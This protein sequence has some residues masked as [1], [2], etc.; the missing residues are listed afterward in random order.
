MEL[1]TLF[2]ALEKTPTQQSSSKINLAGT[3]IESLI[4]A[5]PVTALVPWISAWEELRRPR[6]DLGHGIGIAYPNGKIAQ[7]KPIVVDAGDKAPI[8][9]KQSSERSLTRSDVRRYRQHIYVYTRI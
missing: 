4:P 7:G 5:P 1:T 6:C 9:A 8:G 3:P 2:S